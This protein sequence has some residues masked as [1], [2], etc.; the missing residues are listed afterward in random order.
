MRFGC[1][2][3]VGLGGESDGECADMAHRCG[4]VEYVLRHTFRAPAHQKTAPRQKPRGGVFFCE[5]LKR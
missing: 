2:C 4:L 5:A 1:G 3:G